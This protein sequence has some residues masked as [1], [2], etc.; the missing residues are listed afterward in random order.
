MKNKTYLSKTS[1]ASLIFFLLFSFGLR[2]QIDVTATAGTPFSS[3]ATLKDAFDAINAGT[4]MGVVTVDI[5]VS[6]TE[7]SSCVLNSSGAGSASYTSVLVRPANDGV[8]VSGSSLSGRGVIELNGADNVTIDGDNPNTPGTNRNLT[9]SNTASNTTTYASVV[10]IAL[11]TIVTSANDNTVKNC[12]IS[13]N[14]SGRNIATATSTVGSENTTYGI[15]VA[16]SAS[17]VAATSVPN[18]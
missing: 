18:E 2:S 5:Y 11:S 12:I 3:Y 1:F 14:A 13:G 7:I 4:H 6:T 10:R 15:L 9:I 8:S 17:T 16:G